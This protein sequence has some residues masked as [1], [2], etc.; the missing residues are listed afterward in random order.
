MKKKFIF[1]TFW[2]PWWLY[3]KF[4]PCLGP[5]IFMKQRKNL[6]NYKHL[7]STCIYTMWMWVKLLKKKEISHHDL[8]HMINE[9]WPKGQYKDWD[10]GERRH[11]FILW[12][13]KWIWFGLRKKIS[14]GQSSKKRSLRRCLWKDVWDTRTQIKALDS[15]CHICV[16]GSEKK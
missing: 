15:R 16:V 6:I 10:F 3:W 14:N 9:L 4:I 8:K 1:M 13:V 12:F 5:D 11:T 7:F 2:T